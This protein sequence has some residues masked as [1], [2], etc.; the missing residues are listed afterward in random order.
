[1]LIK[2]THLVVQLTTKINQ[3]RTIPKKVTS[4]DQN[5][6][7][8]LFSLNYVTVIQTYPHGYCTSFITLPCDKEKL[9]AKVIKKKRER[10]PD[11]DC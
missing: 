8:K 4:S 1:M 3:C 11:T 10:Q 5:E 9:C 7:D 2:I 6:G